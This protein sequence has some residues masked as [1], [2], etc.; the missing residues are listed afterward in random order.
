MSLELF[1]LVPLLGLAAAN[2]ANDVAKGVATL[3]GS[4]VTHYRAA[5]L[6]GAVTTL[7]GVLLS[8]FIAERL[9]RL[10]TA[11]IVTAPPSGG[12]TLAVTAGAVGWV[13]LATVT[14]LPVSTTHSIIG[15]LIGAGL[16]FAPESIAWPVV[17]PKLALPLLL[18]I[19]V[20]FLFSAGLNR[21]FGAQA[22]VAA[23]CV[24]V[25]VVAMET[26]VDRPAQLAVWTGPAAKCRA[27]SASGFM[28]TADTL[29]WLSGGAVGF[30]RGLNDGPKLVAIGAVVVGPSLPP[31]PLLILVGLAMF[32]GSVYAGGRVARVLAERVVTMGPREGLLA[33]LATSLLVGVGANLGLPMSTTHVATG[34]IAGIAGSEPARLNRTT[35]RDL[36]LAWTATPLV[37]GLMA[38][39]SYSALSTLVS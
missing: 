36:V 33:N 20:A 23:D 17:V 38:F 14:R 34:A 4:G 1:A 30:A 18:S 22:V 25:D 7:A 37:A 32:A 2:G 35:A 39:A 13:A 28:L 12:F 29:H 15:A 11:G 31:G 10:F 26:G 21:V 9:L 6:W 19:G 3:V 8:G 24:C 16:A 27:E 5:I